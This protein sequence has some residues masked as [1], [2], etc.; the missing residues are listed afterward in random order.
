M[1]RAWDP[2]QDHAP[3]ELIQNGPEDPEIKK[4]VEYQTKKDQEAPT[5]S[6]RAP[7]TNKESPRERT[8][9]DITM[10][11]FQLRAMPSHVIDS[12]YHVSRLRP[13]MRPHVSA[14]HSFLGKIHVNAWEHAILFSQ[15]LLEDIMATLICTAPQQALS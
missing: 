2:C 15:S 13:C 7:V 1:D 14:L 6:S 10:K 5:T 3:I 8:I 4:S 12:D 11:N 9:E